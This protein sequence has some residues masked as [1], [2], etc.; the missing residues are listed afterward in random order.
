MNAAV[1]NL[2]RLGAS[3]RR[4]VAIGGSLVTG[5][6]LSLGLAQFRVLA[7]RIAQKDEFYR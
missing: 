2:K 3:K 1:S 7:S 5:R 4:V 6:G